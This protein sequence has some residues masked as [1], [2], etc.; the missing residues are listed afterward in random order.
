MGTA[1]LLD[2]AVIGAGAAGTWTADAV[3]RARPDWSI[4]LFERSTR[5][6]GRLHS[7]KIDGLAH[8]IELGGMRFLTSHPLVAATVDEFGLSTRPFD[9]RGKPERTFLRGVPGDGPDD[10]YAGRGYQLPEHE[11]DRSSMELRLTAFSTIVPGY[12]SLDHE[13]WSRMRASAQYLGRPL[14]DWSMFEAMATVLSPEGLRFVADSFG[15]FSGMGPFNA[16]DGI[17]YLSGSGDPTGEARVPVT[18][19][20][21]LPLGLAGRFIAGGGAIHLGQDLQGCDMVDGG[22]L[23]RFGDRQV[24]A[25]H[26]VLTVAIPALRTLALGSRTLD[27]PN[28]RRVM[29]SVEGFPATKLYL[30][31][32]RPWWRDGPAA[33]PGIRTTTDLVNRKVLYFDEHMDAPAAVLAEYTDGGHLPSW[34]DLAG[35]VSNGEPAPPAMLRRIGEL[36]REIHPTVDIPDPNGSAFMHWGSD[37]QETGWTFWS[38]GVRS[39][40]IIE[41]A[42]KPEP[43]VPIFVAGEAFS[44]SQ[45][46]V[47]GAF[48]TAQAV[49]DRLVSA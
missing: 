16:G 45:G 41:L 32:R 18:G 31:F 15:Y 30:W 23:L 10:P 8:P 26:V 13:G 34:V 46:W 39:D 28:W 3:L 12:D 47:E 49:V 14:T 20:D 40:E 22:V 11:R 4:A 7:V 25:R 27:T 19:M 37:P 35:G 6:G 48:K 1:E 42:T 24:V 2:L 9:T 38:A 17:Q 36:L 29:A 43:D 21:S 44:R 33:V 5:I